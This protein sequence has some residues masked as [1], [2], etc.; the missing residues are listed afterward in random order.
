MSE[1]Q[2]LFYIHGLR[3]ILYFPSQDFRA[4]DET[5]RE[6]VGDAK[7]REFR[8]G[9]GPVDFDTKVRLAERTL[10]QFL[11]AHKD[12][13]YDQESFLLLKDVHKQLEDGSVIALL[14]YI[15]ERTLYSEDYQQTIVI[16]SGEC[17]IP[18]EI[19]HLVTIIP[20]EVPSQK[21][22]EK[23]I[24]D[25][26]EQ[27][28]FTIDA[29]PAKEEEIV[30]KLALELKGFSFFQIK[31]VLDLAYANGGKISFEDKDF[32]LLEKKQIINKSGLLEYLEAD[33]DAESIGGLEALKKW[34]RRKAMIFHDL[35]RALKNG[36]DVPK[37]V[38]I[39]GVPGCGK[40]LTAKTTAAMFGVP[41]LRLDVG[42]I[43]GKYVG[44]SERNMRAALIQAEAVSPCVLWVDEVEKAFA[45][46]T[47]DKGH[48]VTA[49]LIGQF[50]T[51]M[52]EKSSTVFV[53]ATAND[54][55]NL[56]TEFLRKGRFDEI[57]SVDL[58]T[59]Q[60]RMQILKIHLRKRKQY[61]INL[62]L[63]EVVKQTDGFSGADLE[64]G[65][66][67]AVEELFLSGQMKDGLTASKLV[68]AFSD[69]T[70]LSL[71]LRGKFAKIKEKLKEYSVKPAHDSAH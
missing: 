40:S 27:L 12:T 65:V 37:G 23:I 43:L 34:L 18:P 29:E 16:V 20:Q 14:K 36:V 64:A 2:I 68:D 55:E 45:G 41:L 63:S 35:D 61:H 3:P 9:L 17:I 57:F 15:S 31:Q 10:V 19:A 13:G 25:Y 52:Q 24:R 62:D 56:P 46:G 44:E 66:A 8:Q 28:N 38:L 71:S 53:V 58:P 51:W 49:R 42:K 67:T 6:L 11:E 39:V 32:I 59:P 48:E 70:P 22:I 5:L 47:G 60:E 7:I 50:L 69:I 4:V 26:A 54:L 1:N 21:E 30:G 33:C